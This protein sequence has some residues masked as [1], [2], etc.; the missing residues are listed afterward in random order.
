MVA[1]FDG[2]NNIANGHTL[3]GFE[4][5]PI[6]YNGRVVLVV[7]TDVKNNLQSE[8]E[9]FEEI[10]ELDGWMVEELVADSNSTVETIKTAINGEYEEYNDLTAVLLIGDI[11]VPYSGALNFDG[12]SDHTGAWA[13]DM[14]YGEM[15]IAEW[16]DIAVN[17]DLPKRDENKN[18]PGDGKYDYSF[19]YTSSY[20]TSIQVESFM[21]LQVGRVDMSALPAFSETEIELIRRYLQKNMAYRTGSFEVNRQAVVEDNFNFAQEGFS[22]SGW[23]SFIPMF[24]EENVFNADPFDSLRK[25]NFSWVYGSGAGSYTSCGGIGN[26][27]T[28]AGSDSLLGVFSMM[29]GSYFGDWDISNNF[30]RGMLANRGSILTCSWSGRPVWLYHHMTL[31]HNIG[32]SALRSQNNAGNGSAFQL[33]FW[34]S[35]FPGNLTMNLMGDPTLKLHTFKGPTNFTASTI[36]DGKY[37]ELI[38]TASADP[39]VEGY[40]LYRYNRAK[41]HYELLV[42]AMLTRTNYIDSFPIY[43]EMEYIVRAVK[44]EET[45]SGSYY[46]LSAG[47]GASTDGLE[48]VAGIKELLTANVYPVPASDHITIELEESISN[49]IIQVTDAS[50][51][52]RIEKG[53]NSAF[54]S[55]NL[56]LTGLEDGYYLLKIIG[57]KGTFSKPFIKAEN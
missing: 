46:N 38:W 1:G 17:D 57:E 25:R 32:L 37:A 20:P 11:P 34:G 40:Y 30:L 39:E 29:F 14:Y 28:L 45:P 4:A 35:A 51:R 44:L 5:Q 21:D 22:Q 54:L 47:E 3:A 15:D 31:G 48:A 53:W 8:L 56:N 49:A 18:V 12:H 42:D 52:L 55:Q 33:Q 19:L 50:G 23:R 2:T 43:E 16:G 27:N 9:E 13:T 26:I 6:H 24:G 7:H 36:N 10:L 41:R